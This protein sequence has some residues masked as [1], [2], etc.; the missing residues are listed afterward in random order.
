MYS[1]VITRFRLKM[2]RNRAA[3]YRLNRR[4]FCC[5]ILPNRCRLCSFL[6]LL[7]YRHTVKSGPFF[8]YLE[9]E[10]QLRTCLAFYHDVGNLLSIFPNVNP[11]GKVQAGTGGK[12]CLFNPMGR[13]LRRTVLGAE[14]H[15]G[16]R[17]NGV[18]I[19]AK[20]SCHSDTGS[21]ISVNSL[22]A[23]ER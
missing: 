12:T 4:L 16:N 9:I 21:E 3:V 14:D 8:V 13:H 6:K 19:A 15:T 11:L 2:N 18:G 1:M 5:P 22:Q 7:S 10:S 23:H 20:V 17:A